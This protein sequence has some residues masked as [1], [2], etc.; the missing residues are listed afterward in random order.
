MSKNS[1]TNTPDQNQDASLDPTK[2]VRTGRKIFKDQVEPTAPIPQKKTVKKQSVKL[3]AETEIPVET[4]EPAEVDG[5]KPKVRRGKWVWLGI[6]IMLVIIAIGS[7]IGYQSA[8]QARMAEDTNHRLEL[9]TTQFLKA[10]QDQAA[11]NLNMA[12]D[13]L[14]YVM[15]I[16]P[17]YPGVTEKLAEVMLAISLSSSQDPNPQPT[18]EV[19]VTAVPT[20]DTSVVSELF[21]QAQNQL[22]AQ[23]WPGL[24]NTVNQMRNLNPAYESIKVDGMFYYAL[25]YNG[26]LK[27]QEGELEVGLY[28]FAMAETIAPLDGDIESWRRYAQNYIYA[29]TWYG[30]NWYKAA[31]AFYSVY[32]DV[33]YLMDSSK[34]TSKQRY[35]NSLEGIGDMMMLEMKKDYFCQAV[36][37]YEKAKEI[38]SNDRLVGK[39]AQAKEY[40][41]NPPATPTP[42]VDPN[43]PTPTPT[44]GG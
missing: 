14:E 42:T 40:C 22:T 27:I 28:Y 43:A 12:Q 44:D 35:V 18:P 34:I 15:T 39:I 19:V 23:D 2:P 13:R 17:N 36:D 33:P 6:L 10:E 1:Q 7:G 24:L 4:S 31:E 30:V 20:K 37:Q 32:Q 9:A 11:G 8:L 29:G 16:Y 21:I 25:R 3:E 41:E 38:I 26:I 5:K